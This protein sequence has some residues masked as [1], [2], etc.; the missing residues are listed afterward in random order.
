MTH[1]QRMFAVLQGR[2]VERIPWVPRLDLWHR[3]NQR[4]G[5][6]AQ[7]LRQFVAHGNGRRPGLRLPRGDPQF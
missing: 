3:A 4:R 6:F 7:P 5:N 1:K 2:A